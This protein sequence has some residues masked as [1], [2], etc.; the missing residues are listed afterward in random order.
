L[1]L[2]K[3]HFLKYFEEEGTDEELD[4]LLSHIA[5]FTAEYHREHL[6]YL[7]KMKREMK[8]LF[9]KFS[10]ST[11]P[12]NVKKQGA[13]TGDKKAGESSKS[14]SDEDDKMRPVLRRR[15]SRQGEEERVP[16]PQPHRVIHQPKP[17]QL[18]E[19]SGQSDSEPDFD[20]VSMDGMSVDGGSV[21]PSPSAGASS[22]S[23]PTSRPGIA[24]RSA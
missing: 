23:T 15:A 6:K 4:V 3:A 20:D 1:R 17:L 11:N 10:P 19:L 22:A 21:P 18:D 16:H 14:G 9:K 7:E 8:G 5:N 12:L 24:T 13:S 2:Q